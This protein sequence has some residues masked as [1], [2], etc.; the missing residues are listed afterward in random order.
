MKN[1]R[2]ILERIA[3]I[4]RHPDQHRHTF[5]ELIKCCSVNGSIDTGLLGIHQQFASCGKTSR[6][7]VTEGPCACGAWHRKGH[8][9]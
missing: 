1:K 3:D 5:E 9:D 2:E 6:C 7:D 4:K 8:N